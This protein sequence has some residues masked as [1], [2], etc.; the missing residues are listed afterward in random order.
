MSQPRDL[1]CAGILVAVSMAS[2]LLGLVTAVANAGERPEEQTTRRAR[3]TRVLDGDTVEVEYTIQ[4]VVR[5][6]DCWAPE[7]RTRN[8]TEKAAGTD[9]KARLT[10]LVLGRLVLVSIPHESDDDR[11]VRR[12]GQSM[13]FGRVV[14]TVWLDGLDHDLSTQM[15]NEGHATRTKAESREKFPSGR[16]AKG[17]P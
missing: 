6:K 15:I 11:P 3:V 16:Y 10:E 12:I 9:A 4:A 14:G 2:I 5:L 7:T 17:K 1:P 8:L 13:S